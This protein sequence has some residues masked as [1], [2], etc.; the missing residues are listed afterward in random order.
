MGFEVRSSASAWPWNKL[1]SRVACRVYVCGSVIVIIFSITLHIQAALFGAKTLKMVHALSKLRVG[2]TS[3]AETLKE[4]SALKATQPD[5]FGGS[6]CGAD[7]CFST[8]LAT[9][10]FMDSALRNI[11]PRHRIIFA[12]LNW[13]GVRGRYFDL[14]VE[15]KSGVVSSFGYQLMVTS[16]RADYPYVV[17]V[18]VSAVQRIA[19]NSETYSVKRARQTPLQ[20]V[21]IVFTPRAP[22]QITTPA[23]NPNMSCLSS[24]GGCRTWPDVLPS[25]EQ[26]GT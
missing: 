9:T 23:F 19:E 22:I 21:G 17:V 8:R 2:L 1:A 18:G 11:V 5:P 12:I 26:L 16:A 7:E 20:S 24:L 4:L 6:R 15:F 3:K 25:F 14:H 10:G 13:L